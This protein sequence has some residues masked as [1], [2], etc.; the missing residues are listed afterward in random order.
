MQVCSAMPYQLHEQSTR[1]LLHQLG[2]R[3]RQTILRRHSIHLA[4]NMALP[5]RCT[6]AFLRFHLSQT[7][8]TCFFLGERSLLA[9]VFLMLRPALSGQLSRFGRE[10]RLPETLDTQLSHECKASGSEEHLLAHRCAVGHE[11]DG[12]E[13]I[14]LARCD[15]EQYIAGG[16]RRE[17]GLQLA[18]VG[19]EVGLQGNAL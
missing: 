8:L 12:H 1:A 18:K 19:G 15:L 5:G 2:Q 6:T 9:T 13:A 16:V 3:F 11:G 4:S 7:S 17:V 10:E 14:G